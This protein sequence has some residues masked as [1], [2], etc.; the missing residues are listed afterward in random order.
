[1]V[2]SSMFGSWS[3]GN[4][5]DGHHREQQQV[6]TGEPVAPSV[7]R[8]AARSSSA[9]SQVRCE[10]DA[11]SAASSGRLGDIAGTIMRTK[12]SCCSAE[13]DRRAFVVDAG[14]QHRRGG[15]RRGAAGRGIPCRPDDAG[16]SSQVPMRKSRSEVTSLGG[17]SSRHAVARSGSGPASTVE[18][19]V[20]V[21]GA[22]RD[23]AEHVDVDIGRAAADVVEVAPLRDH[24]E[25]RL[26]SEHAAAV[27][28]ATHRTADVGAQLEAGEAGRD[29]GRGP[30][31]RSAHRDGRG[32]RGCG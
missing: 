12:R 14:H 15:R 22:A 26:Q 17:S 20:E 18:Q 3:C 28:W 11:A 31:R 16:S 2:R 6:V 29:R 5:G 1:M 19:K 7:R 30:A 9:R 23:R 8:S 13:L 4:A 32:S 10:P 21:V 27:R 24:A 25:A